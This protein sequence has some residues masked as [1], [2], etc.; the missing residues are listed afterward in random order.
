MARAD[1]CSNGREWLVAGESLKLAGGDDASPC[2]ACDAGKLALLL[3]E[4]FTCELEFVRI[5]KPSGSK[6]L[7]LMLLKR[8]FDGVAYVNRYLLI[9]SLIDRASENVERAA[10]KRAM[11]DTPRQDTPWTYATSCTC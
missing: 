4:L 1:S 2:E 10:T 5:L 3:A 7:V 9:Y 11:H 6:K 8:A